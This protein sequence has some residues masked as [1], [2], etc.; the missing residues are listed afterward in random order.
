MDRI[1]KENLK[2]Q[3]GRFWIRLDERKKVDYLR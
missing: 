1:G 2:N 3:S